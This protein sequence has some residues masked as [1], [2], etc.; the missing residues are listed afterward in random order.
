MAKKRASKNKRVLLHIK[1]TGKRHANANTSFP[2]LAFILIS[3]GFLLVNLTYQAHAA[4]IKVLDARVPGVAPTQPAV[5]TTPSTNSSVSEIPLPV[6]GTCPAGTIVKIFRNGLFT[7]AAMCNAEGKFNLS[8]DLFVGANELTAR[9][10]NLGDTEGPTS[11]GINVNYQ[12][13]ELAIIDGAPVSPFVTSELPFLLKTQIFYRG[14][15]VGDTVQW[16]FTAV[17]GTAPYAVSADWGDGKTSVISVKNT[18]VFDMTHIY[19]K[20]GNYKGGY[21]IKLTGSDSSGK[22]AFLQVVAIINSLRG[23]SL[24]TSPTSSITTPLTEHASIIWSA[25]GGVTLMT[26]SFWLGQK[27]GLALFLS[28]HRGPR[29]RPRHS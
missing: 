14:Y 17:G 23:N 8:T 11:P 20:P 25:Y 15:N 26:I 1:Q 2:L 12:I 13:P 9:V 3:V 22:Q 29:I 5:I 7:G 24:A 10:Y 19:T 21:A 27:R 28:R 4:D 16:R 6:S 18:E